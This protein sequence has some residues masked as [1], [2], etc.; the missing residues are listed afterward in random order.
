MSWHT[1]QT[2][3]GREYGSFEAFYIGNDG[4][5]YGFT[6]LDPD[7]GE[8][9]VVEWTNNDQWTDPVTGIVYEFTDGVWEEPTPVVDGGDV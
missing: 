6:Y 2:E 5:A 7:T 4:S 9:T 8:E 1:F 3:D